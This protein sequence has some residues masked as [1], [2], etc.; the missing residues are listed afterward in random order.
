M[1]CSRLI[2]KNET[3]SRLPV[4][5][6]RK[7]IFDEL[8]RLIRPAALSSAA[9]AGTV[10]RLPQR[11]PSALAPGVASSYS[12]GPTRALNFAPESS[13]LPLIFY[14]GMKRR[15]KQLPLPRAPSPTRYTVSPA[16]F[17][18]LN[19]TPASIHS[20]ACTSVRDLLGGARASRFPY[21]LIRIRSE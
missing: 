7:K 3:D 4:N 18:R 11:Q 16:W 2:L 8:L 15:S 20:A 12:A 13:Y 5:G 17:S 1:S 19:R 14:Q 10:D 6:H 21:D 9:T